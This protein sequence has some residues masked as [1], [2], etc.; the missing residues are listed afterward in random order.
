MV[1]LVVIGPERLPSAARYA[2]RWVGKMKRMFN[3]VKQELDRELHIDEAKRAL[4]DS[5]TLAE[6]KQDLNQLQ[7][8]SHQVE[9]EIQNTILPPET[10]PTS[11]TQSPI[12]HDSASAKH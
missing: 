10:A 1:A 11:P 3:E 9:Q 4:E 2:G 12:S 8:Q 6:L 5:T 7:Q